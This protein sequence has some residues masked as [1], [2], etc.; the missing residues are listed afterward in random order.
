VWV[1]DGSV[2]KPANVWFR[3]KPP[4]GRSQPR[5]EMCSSRSVTAGPGHGAVVA[6]SSARSTSTAAEERGTGGCAERPPVVVIPSCTTGVNAVNEASSPISGWA[7]KR[8][9]A[10]LPD[11]ASVAE[12]DRVNHERAHPAFPGSV[13]RRA[14]AP[15]VVAERRPPRRPRISGRRSWTDSAT[16]RRGPVLDE[17]DPPQ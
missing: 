6:D 14:G 16:E 17:R 13:T 3:H 9:W 15:S 12:F 1:S 10:T 8:N 11:V 5:W 2:G 4:W 7:T